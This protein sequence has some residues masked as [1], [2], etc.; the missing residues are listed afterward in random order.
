MAASP[1]GLRRNHRK[2][3]IVDGDR[4]LIGGAGILR[5]LGWLGEN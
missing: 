1:G 4:L 3:L 5:S 2:L